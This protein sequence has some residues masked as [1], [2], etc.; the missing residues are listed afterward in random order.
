MKTLKQTIRLLAVTAIGFGLL[1]VLF[2]QLNVVAKAAPADQLDV[3]ATCTY[4]TIQTAVDAAN[5]G[6][7]IRVA[8]GTYQDIV[9]SPGLLTSTVII[10][11]DLTL[12]GGYS[13][14]FQ[15]HDPNQ[16]ETIVDGQNIGKGFYVSGSYAHIEG[17]TI[18]NGYTQ[19]ILVRESIVNNA[20]AGATLVNNHI[21][22]NVSGVVIVLA[23]VTI[24]SNIIADNS[25]SG[26]A[27][28]DA[29]TAVMSST[30]TQNNGGI[31]ATRS[32]VTIEGNVISNNI[33]DWSGGGIYV[34]NGA[35]ALIVH[36]EITGNEAGNGGGIGTF[37]S[38]D[39][40]ISH[41]V[42]TDN[43]ATEGGGGGVTIDV[44]S[45]PPFS[46]TMTHNII[47]GNEAQQYGGGGI[48]VF[49]RAT[50][51]ISFNEITNNI[52]MSGGGGG[53][54]A[55]ANGDLLISNNTIT[56]NSTQEGG[57]G[58]DFNPDDTA[59]GTATFITI[60]ENIVQENIGSFGS[61]IALN[62]VNGGTY[63]AAND[64]RLNEMVANTPDYQ[65]GG[66]HIWGS[67]GAI[68]VVNNL[69]VQNANRALKVA[70]FSQLEVINNTIVGNGAMAIETFAWPVTPTLPYTATVVNNIMVGH[71]ECGVS[72]FNGVVMY[73]D[74]NLFH[75]N[76]TDI[77]LATA[78]PPHANIFADPQ[79]VNPAAGNYQLLS[80]SPAIDSG[81]TGPNVPNVDIEGN[82]RPQ[83]SGVDMGAYEATR[84]ALFLPVT[85]KPVPVPSDNF[86]IVNRTFGQGYSAYSGDVHAWLSNSDGWGFAPQDP[87]NVT[88]YRWNGTEW[89]S[90]Q[91]LPSGGWY[92]FGTDLK[93]LS[94]SEGWAVAP[95]SG[96]GPSTFFRWDGAQWIENASISAG[97][98]AIDFRDSNDGWAVGYPPY[99]CGS[100]FFHWDGSSWTQQVYL[101]LNWP[102]SDIAL[103]DNGDGWA[104]GSTIAR[105]SGSN[106]VVYGSPVTESLNALSMVS[107]D[108]GWIV[109]DAG[110][111]LRWDGAT[112]T[113]V[114]SPTTEDLRDIEM[115]QTNHGWAVGKNGTILR[116]NGS[117]WSQVS[118]PV[119]ANFG[120]LD[121]V[122][123]NEG[124]IPYYH[125]ATS[126]SGV[127]HIT[128]P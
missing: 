73:V 31:Y 122:G 87:D 38:G 79:F 15:T 55:Y 53:I 115:V 1:A 4:T 29:A 9:T 66:I 33:G 96:E 116:W 95:R 70:D 94:T 51:N 109:G 127:L 2:T 91:T 42:I 100:L 54:S 119:T 121:M 46:F 44:G 11:K 16:Y 111:I 67:Q 17:F 19:G 90:F 102:V 92:F 101:Q 43:L 65:A 61:G 56:G 23:D 110:T 82:T 114:T 52:H 72:G 12:I 20:P 74:Y 7:T 27:I 13:P 89:T 18:I 77:C 58:L 99:C 28:I 106:W 76:D 41:N 86:T 85:V 36:N 32:N 34:E 105:Q 104:V 60:T 64:I 63:I 117:V 45:A 48:V 10:T 98:T 22:N 14:D 50:G 81:T 3:C 124:W 80:G 84:Y 21:R 103:V 35:T 97:I 6:D 57:G 107:A 128:T 8:Q 88:F 83:G 30:I 125:S 123:V 118:S 25:G 120:E 26:I 113:A 49:G 78:A 5:P 71:S 37:Q 112:W 69:L 47:N 75:T 126:T 62:N 40:T 68:K 39:L 108:D 93:M 59:F 24:D